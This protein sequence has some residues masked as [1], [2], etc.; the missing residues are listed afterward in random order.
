MSKP[1]SEDLRERVV[2]AVEGGLLRRH[3]AGVASLSARPS[4]SKKACARSSKSGLMWPQATD[5]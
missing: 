4:R 3:A 2:A 5:C 1:Y